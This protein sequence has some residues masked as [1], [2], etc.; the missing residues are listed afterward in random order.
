MT[1]YRQLF[2]STFAVG[3]VMLQVPHHAAAQSVA[4]VHQFCWVVGAYDNTVY[5]AEVANREDRSQSFASSIDISGIGHA[6]VYCENLSHS[7]YPQRREAL[8]KAWQDM[9]YERANT[10]FLSDLDF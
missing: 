9:G 5:Y 6:G 8:F 2:L 4:A 7:D 10:T 1:R 3:L